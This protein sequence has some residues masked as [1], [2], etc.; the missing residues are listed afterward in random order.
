MSVV[1]GVQRRPVELLMDFRGPVL[2]FN[3]IS[4][5]I[6]GLSFAVKAGN[7]VCLTPVSLNFPQCFLRTQL[8]VFPKELLQFTPLN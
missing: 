7:V 2:Q 6:E 1:A 3:L 5:F 8:L 4:D